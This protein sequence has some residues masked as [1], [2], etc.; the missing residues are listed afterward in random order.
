[1]VPQEC[2]V[3]VHRYIPTL[4]K[5]RVG[6]PPPGCGMIIG[7]WCIIYL[8]STTLAGLVVGCYGVA[9]AFLR[10]MMLGFRRFHPLLLLLMAMA[11]IPDEKVNFL[12]YTLQLHSILLP[13]CAKIFAH[14]GI[15]MHAAAAVPG[16]GMLCSTCV[17]K[18]LIGAC[19]AASTITCVCAGS[20]THT[21][22]EG[23]PFKTG[24]PGWFVYKDVQ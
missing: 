24:P 2:V 13:G 9:S 11:Y 1:M 21:A 15:S 19:L 18:P 23:L 7:E 6:R 4:S 10:M 8:C 20:S 16:T 22:P 5:H 3:V 14:W 12:L 17:H